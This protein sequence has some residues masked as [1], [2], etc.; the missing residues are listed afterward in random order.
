M[1]RS[2]YILLFCALAL[3]A[4]T[5]YLDIKPY[6]KTIPK[7]P[8]EF[9]ALLHAIIE[10]ID[11]GEEIIVGDVKSVADLECY[12]DNLEANLTE[13]PK[14]DYL[15]LYIGTHLSG[16][17]RRYK[18]LYEVIKDC[19]IILDNMTDKE[20]ELAKEVL[21]TAYSIRGI[22]YYNLLRDFCEPPVGNMQ[23]LG[24]PLIV[25]FDMEARLPRSSIAQT[26]RQAEQDMLTALKYNIQN[27]LYRIT[28]DVME[29]Y[30][31]RLYFWV[32]EWNSASEYA[33]RVM[34]KHAMVTGNEYT[35][36][37][38]A[39]LSARGNMILKSAIL[40]D[41]TKQ[42]QF[43]NQ[44]DLVRSRPLSKRFVELFVEKEKD[45]RYALTFDKWRL[46][47]KSPFAGMRT[48]EMN[49]IL[50]ESLYH[51]GDKPG[52]LAALNEFRRLRIDGVTDYTME[53]LPDVKTDGLITNDVYG[54]PLTPLLNAI[55]NERNKE[56]YMEGDRWYELKRNGR[57]EFWVAKQG[58]KYTT[59]SYMY[60]F[61]F[62]IQDVELVDGMI[63]NPGYDKVE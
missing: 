44:K 43:S 55:L 61:P 51:S 50:I 18:D 47:V 46:S 14:G 52:A 63:Q 36:M 1:K 9:A 37:L 57:P 53:T 2:I 48:A 20:S 34:A 29:G 49:L 23:G 56:L 62:P 25:Q 58:R 42:N 21:G 3:T 13:Y 7:T 45:I 11:Y 54:N 4:C 22:C 31:A 19:N 41:A 40:Y 59:F 28:A 16:K 10:D 38:R 15:P 32:G 12:S 24:M 39:E 5:K 6:G 35:N 33:G 30:L 26:F 27:K 8:D 17:T 60:T